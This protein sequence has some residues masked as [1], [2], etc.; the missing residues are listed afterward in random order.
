MPLRDAYPHG[1][2]E[3]I[4]QQ[5]DGTISWQENDPKNSKAGI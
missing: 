5:P 2:N 3:D 1:K 4:T